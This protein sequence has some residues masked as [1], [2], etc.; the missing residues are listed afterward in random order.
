MFNTL[1]NWF[2]PPKETSIMVSTGPCRVPFCTEICTGGQ[3]DIIS[4][5]FVPESQLCKLCFHPFNLHDTLTLTQ[6]SSPEVSLPPD[7][8]YSLDSI[9]VEKLLPPQHTDPYIYTR[10]DTIRKLWS[11]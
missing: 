3:F 6:P 11:Q 4:G 8:D 5:Q 7:F 9:P 10:P 1:A 2:R